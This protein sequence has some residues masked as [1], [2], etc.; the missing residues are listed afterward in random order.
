MITG[1]LR[2]WD[3]VWQGCAAY[4]ASGATVV[5]RDRIRWFATGVGYEGLNGV[6]VAPGTPA[7]PVEDATRTFHDLRVPALWHIASVGV[8]AGP[9][10]PAASLPG[11]SWYEEE[12]LMTAPIGRYEP[13]HV[14]GLSVFAVRDEPG[15]RVWVRIWSGQDSGRVFQGLVAARAAVGA[16]FVHL[17]A[18]LAG[19]TVG[20]AAVFLGTEG[21]ELQHVVT[22]PTA[23]RRGVGTAIVIAALRI[24]AA[25]GLDTA[26][27]TSSPDGVRIYQRLGFRPVGRIRRYLWTPP[28]PKSPSRSLDRMAPE[29]S[30]GRRTM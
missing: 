27:L 12:P 19:D 4:A 7:V 6:F 14:D 24:A 20:C 1:A 2:A 25:R 17:V 23:R 11:L 3:V 16:G 5:E 28:P 18:V 9:A 30:T 29:T 22:V 10:E 26:V 15:I 13:P 8:S 21:A